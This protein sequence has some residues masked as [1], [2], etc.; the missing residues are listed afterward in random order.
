MLQLL[1]RIHRE[2]EGQDVIEYALLGGFVS[3]AGIIAVQAIAPL[4]QGIFEDIQAALEGWEGARV[5]IARRVFS[6]GPRS[7]AAFMS[8]RFLRG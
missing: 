6:R 5:R 2:E 8:G 4:V 1:M 7:A 3:L